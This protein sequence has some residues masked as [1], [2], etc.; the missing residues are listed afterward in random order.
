MARYRN[1]ICSSGF[2]LYG[3][4]TDLRWSDVKTQAG[5]RKD[6]PTDIAS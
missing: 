6:L 2:S 1:R 4:L 3:A 5:G